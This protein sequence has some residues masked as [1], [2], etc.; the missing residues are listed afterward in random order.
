MNTDMR[1]SWRLCLLVGMM[2]LSFVGA[3]AQQ[4]GNFNPAKFEA[5]LEQYI[6]TQAGLT[7]QEASRF[8]PLYREMRTKQMALFGDERRFRHIDTSDD[9][10]CA[11]AIR[12]H[13][14][15]E[16]AMKELLQTYHNKFMKILPAGRVFRIIRAE[17]EFHRQVFK[18]VAKRG[19]K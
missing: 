19:H 9:K 13:D 15:N 12:K 1:R 6:T 17:D 4:P 3:F 8:F 5:E 18:R 2:W 16:I 7:P 11:E 14:S 10:A